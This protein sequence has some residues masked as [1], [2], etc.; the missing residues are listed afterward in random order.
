MKTGGKF[1]IDVPGY[2]GRYQYSSD[3]ELRSMARSAP[4][5]GGKSR[6][7]FRPAILKGIVDSDGNQAYDLFVDGTPHR[8]LKKNLDLIID[9]YLLK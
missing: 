4:A 5:K 9:R 2:N 1:W 6:L 8:V 7:L 3:R